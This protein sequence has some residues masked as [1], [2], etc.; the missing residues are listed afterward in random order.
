MK[1]SRAIFLLLLTVASFLIPIPGSAKECHKTFRFRGIGKDG[2]PKDFAIKFKRPLVETPSFNSAAQETMDTKTYGQFYSIVGPPTFKQN[3]AGHVMNKLWGTGN[4]FFLA[5]QFFNEIVDV[6]GKEVLSKPQPNDIVVFFFGGVAKHVAVVTSP[7]NSMDAVDIESKDN[8]QSVIA[9]QLARFRQGDPI[10]SNNGDYKIYRIDR[11]SVSV[12]EES[13]GE[14]DVVPLTVTLDV[15][16]LLKGNL[17]PLDGASI[18]LMD[19]NGRT[20]ATAK[21]GPDGKAVVMIPADKTDEARNGIKILVT[22]TGFHD[23]PDTIPDN[24]LTGTEALWNVT[25]SR[26]P[27]NPPEG[28]P[29]LPPG[30]SGMTIDE[31]EKKLKEIEGRLAAAEAKRVEFDKKQ[32]GMKSTVAKPADTLKKAQE[33]LENLKKLKPAVDRVEKLCKDATKASKDLEAIEKAINDKEKAATKLTDELLLLAANCTTAA[34]VKKLRD[35]TA[36][37]QKMVNDLAD[38]VKEARRLNDE[39]KRLKGEADKEAPELAKGVGFVRSIREQEDLAYKAFKEAMEAFG[40]LSPLESA[41]KA[42][43]ASISRDL[44]KHRQAHPVNPLP[45]AAKQRLDSLDARTAALVTGLSTGNAP[46]D[47]NGLV[48]SI[49]TIASEADALAKQY[50]TSICTITSREDLLDKIVGSVTFTGLALQSMLNA[51]TQIKQCEDRLNCGQ[52]LKEVN[53]ALDIGDLEGATKIIAEIKGG[54]CDTSAVERRWTDISN[55]I[56]FDLATARN[57]WRDIAASCDYRAAYEA[58]LVIQKQYPKHPWIVK[59]FPDIERGYRAEEQIRALVQLLVAADRARNY[60]EAEKILA[61]IDS[62]ALPYPCMVAEGKKLRGEY[63]RGKAASPETERQCRQL[64][65]EIR[66][67]IAAKRLAEA[68]QKLKQAQQDC[69]NVSPA[70]FSDLGAAQKELDQ[71]IQQAINDVSMNAGKCEFVVAHQLADQVNQ[72]RPGSFT[73]EFMTNLR[74][75]AQAQSGART[76]LEPGFEAIKQ[77]DVKGAIASLKQAQGVPNLPKCIADNVSK[78][79]KELEKRQ[80]FTELTEKVQ[81][82]TQKCDYKDAATLLGQIKAIV[83]RED[84]ISDWLRTNEPILA[85]LQTREKNAVDLIRQAEVLYSRADTAAATEPVDWNNINLLAKQAM[86]LLIKADSEAPKCMSRQQM[87][88]IRQRLNGLATRKKPEIAASIALLIDTSGSMGENNKMMQAKEAARRAARQVSKTTEIAILNF[89]GSCGGGAMQTAAPFTTDVNVLLAA[90]DSLRPG[91]GTPMYVSTAEAVEYAQRN[92]RGKSRVVVLMSDGGDS[93]RDEQ[94]KAA[95]SIRQS[96][97]PVNTIGFDVGNN[98]QAQGDLGDLAKMTNGRTFSASAADPREI[99]RAFNLAMLPS[100]LKDIDFGSIGSSISG[101]FSQAKSLVQQQNISGALMMLQQANQ[102]APNSPNLNFNLSLLYEAE[103]QLIP[104][105]NH[106]N[107]YL[108]LAPGAA[109]RSDVEN[110][111][112]QIQQELEKN[113]RVIM[114]SSGCKDIL[115]WA[116]TERDVARRSKDAGRIQAI[117]DVLISSQ[118]GECDKARSLSESYKGRYR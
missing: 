5:N 107:N 11:N 66:A 116:Q 21:S 97:I 99:I 14:C 36:A 24:M 117:L 106:A 83:P 57:K 98:Q 115:S 35:G 105:M 53:E 45:A 64:L 13:A 38:P 2:Q 75:Q 34:D 113:P 112:G 16:E 28:D 85:E 67:A 68:S 96:N 56:S 22:L 79:L 62:I 4:T 43:E 91:G 58:A 69:A 73:A 3:C 27:D 59:N 101:Y 70:L 118:R 26:T 95:A 87:E 71:A 60:D 90:I 104:A 30:F 7:S 54:G 6:F 50:L 19:L 80:S 41:I 77:K 32:S 61:Q 110:R 18:T 88:A 12:T 108:R 48:G 55:R 17:R 111:I 81:A 103:D 84:Y 47:T 65:N 94:A 51:E 31:W 49:G 39:L 33:A 1:K 20:I 44:F 40:Q 37:L 72:V 10:I 86:D 25:L 46:L 15:N 52:R 82:D 63:G 8:E 29:N 78:L 23:K 100:L 102:I 76:Y 93:C 114:D 42:A 89:D 109:D 9:G 92:G 74:Q